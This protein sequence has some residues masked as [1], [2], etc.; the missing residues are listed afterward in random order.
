[1]RV[2]AP[3][4]DEVET[5]LQHVATKEKFDLPPDAAREIAEDSKGNLRKALLVLEALKM[6]SYVLDFLYTIIRSFIFPPS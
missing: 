2:A 3:T 5:C 1:M 4:D 6:Q